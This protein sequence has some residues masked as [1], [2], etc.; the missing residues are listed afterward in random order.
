MESGRLSRL[1]N[2]GGG[3]S[4]FESVVVDTTGANI[5]LDFAN[6]AQRMF[7]GDPIIDGDRTISLSNDADALEMIFEFELD[8]PHSI[9][10]PASFRMSDALWDAGTQTWTPFDPGKYQG[11]AYFDG[12][13]WNMNIIGPFV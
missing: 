6:A 2:S 8:V 12:T 3:S 10:F 1:G 7:I 5:A 13:N 9:T 11:T 4:A